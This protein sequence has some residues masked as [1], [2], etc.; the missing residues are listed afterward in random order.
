MQSIFLDSHLLNLFSLFH[1]V[2]HIITYK[3][4]HS[5][6]TLEHH[7]YSVIATLGIF[8]MTPR[9]LPT[10]SCLLYIKSTSL[11]SEA[12]RFLERCTSYIVLPVQE[13]LKDPKP[14]SKVDVLGVMFNLGQTY[15][16]RACTN[17]V[18]F[19]LVCIKCS[20]VNKSML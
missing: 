8:Q 13:K 2:L 18:M 17:L 6:Q 7:M 1:L 9:Q 3:N 20:E 14:L 11:T 15:Q 5:R 19:I 10:F 12:A 16:F 4:V